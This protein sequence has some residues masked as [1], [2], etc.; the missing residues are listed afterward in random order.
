MSCGAG[1]RTSYGGDDRRGWLTIASIVQLVAVLFCVA[2]TLQSNPATVSLTPVVAVEALGAVVS[3]V[4]SLVSRSPKPV[5]RPPTVSAGP[6]PTRASVVAQRLAAPTRGPDS[7]NTRGIYHTRLDECRCT[8]GWAGRWCEVRDARPCNRGLDGSVLHHESLC[9][10]H[11]DEDRG[12][13]Y[14][15]GLPTPEQRPLPAHCSPTVHRSSQLP[16]G[17]PA[18]PAR[19]AGGWQMANVYFEKEQSSPNVG[20]YSPDKPSLEN[21]YGPVPGN[22]ASP[23]ADRTRKPPAGVLPFCSPNVTAHSRVSGCSGGCPEGRAGTLCERARRS[24]CLRDCS[25]HGRCDSGFCWCE[26]GW[27]GID[28]SEHQSGRAAPLLQAQQRLASPAAASGLRIYV[29]DMPS[30]FTTRLLQWRGAHRVGLSRALD[31]RTNASVHSAGSLY[32]LELALHEWL[33][34]SPL[35]TTDPAQAHLFYVPLYLAS[36][37]LYPIVK[38]APQPYYGRGGATI[39]EGGGLR[40]PT[41]RSQQGTLLMLR[42]L[43]HIRTAHPFWNASGGRDHVWLMLHDEGPCFCPKEVRPSIL[44]T[45][46]GYY[47][48]A[49]R[50]W[51]TFDDDLFLRHHE[52]Y[53]N[54]LGRDPKRPDACFERGKDLVVPP[55]KTPR[56]WR[57]AL[58][59]PPPSA[60]ARSKLVF[61]AGDLGFNR[62]AGYS[63]DL[64]QLAYA[65]FCDPKT[66]KQ[67]DC[68]PV[69]YDR[70]CDCECRAD[71]PQN[72]SL[73]KPGVSIQVGA[74]LLTR[75]RVVPLQAPPFSRPCP[76]G[77]RSPPPRYT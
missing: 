16:D 33:L 20:W 51:G 7:C 57:R 15:A 14:C 11:C 1:R 29:Y 13:C 50:Q 27:F 63:H 77:Q 42:A 38:F 55:W 25:G 67:S 69:A 9:A 8:A 56:F 58:R 54:Y 35:R 39:G 47:A 32:A 61:F 21:L 41:D 19:S 5:P 72:C 66:T 45:H 71:M 60:A 64:R 59:E 30:E 22:P 49:P 44:L 2:R 52:F 10:G 4:P 73:W 28:C 53:R 3:G 26:R 6:L 34:D 31:A 48:Q 70:K 43:E 46:Y 74:T 62:I 40:E 12:L 37:F 68:T 18:Y 75:T 65:L 17:R 36:L 23:A 76:S 24:F